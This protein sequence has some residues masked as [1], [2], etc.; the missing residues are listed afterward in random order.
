[1]RDPE[2]TRHLL[3]QLRARGFTLAIDDFGTG[4][5]SLAYLK[6]F[7]IDRIKIDRGFVKDIETNQN[8]AVIVAATIALAH[9]LGLT[10]VAEGVETAAQWGF[11][12]D[13]HGDEAQGYLFA[14]PMPAREFREFI[15]TQALPVPGS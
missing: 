12:R 4:Y 11:L 5:S 6:L 8:D 1:M 14:R 2:I 3:R 15:R 10:V 13:K 9:S 7:S